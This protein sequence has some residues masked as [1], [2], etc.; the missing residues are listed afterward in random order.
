VD[1]INNPI[2][3]TGVGLVLYGSKNQSGSS[4]KKKERSILSRGTH[5]MKKWFDDFF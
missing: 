3:A 5:Q 4:F 2:Y 1:I